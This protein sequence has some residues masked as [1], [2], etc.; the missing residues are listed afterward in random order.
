MMQKVGLH[1]C[2]MAT[3]SDTS[4]IEGLLEHVDPATV[5]G[6]VGKSAGTGHHFDPGR[7]LTERS[8]LDLMGGALGL[9]RDEAAERVSI[10]LSGGAFGVL[11][12][13]VAMLTREEVAGEAPTDGKKRLAIGHAFSATVL[14]EEIGRMGQIEK[15][16]AA[17]ATAMADAGIDDPADVHCVLV[18]SPSL[19]TQAVA[20]AHERGATTVTMDLG[21]GPHSSMSYSNDGSALG[22][23][24]ALGEVDR[25]ALSDDVIRS[26]WSLF[27]SVA[28]TS[29]GGEKRR[30][31]IVLL[32]NA[33]A[34]VSDMVIGHGVTSDMLDVEGVKTALRS[35]GLAFDCCPSASDLQQLVHVF[36][37][38]LRP[39]DGLVRGQ[40]T[41]LLEDM[42]GSKSTKCV[43]GALI[44]SVIGRPTFY[45]SGGERNSHQGPPGGSPVAAV[46]RAA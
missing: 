24:L 28:Q 10:L 14:P 1:V 25:E 44:G 35:A 17:V 5:I 29:S 19:T 4:V 3:P 2:P 46:V 41:T 21:S 40:R 13:H 7:E 8:L 23:A 16:G 20:D 36:A 32:G 39:E 37:K 18:K 43:G 9:T 22:V 42:E 26:D 15:V 45:M 31:E 38:L 30:P 11:T 33:R 27:S 12:P 34:S 6:F